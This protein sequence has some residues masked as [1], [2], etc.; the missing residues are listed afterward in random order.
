ME[1]SVANSGHVTAPGFDDDDHVDVDLDPGDIPLGE[2]FDDEQLSPERREARAASA[3]QRML[4]TEPKPLDHERFKV[5]RLSPE[6]EAPDEITP[7]SFVVTLRGLDERELK[8][9]SRRSMRPSTKA[10]REAGAGP[11][12]RDPDTGNV[13]TVATALMDPD[14]SGSTPESQ[15]L[16]S[17]QGPGPEHVIRRWFAPGEIQQMADRAMELSGWSDEALV[18]AKNS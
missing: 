2:R 7:D 18:R 1:S 15:A 6:G 12:V 4:S 11:R 14:L 16:L 17:Q 5:G 10:E 9:I 8:E 3:L 13:L